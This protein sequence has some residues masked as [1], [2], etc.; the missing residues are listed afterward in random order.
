MT[1]TSN[2]IVFGFFGANLNGALI[3][4]FS[5]VEGNR[6]TEASNDDNFIDHDVL[7]KSILGEIQDG[8]ALSIQTAENQGRKNVCRIHDW[9]EGMAI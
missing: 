4:C 7:L 9:L 2:K 6:L 1:I 3:D 8:Q 5:N